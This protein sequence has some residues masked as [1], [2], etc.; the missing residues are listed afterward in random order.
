[1]ITFTKKTDPQP[2]PNDLE[3]NR[4]EQIRKAAKERQRQSATDGTRRRARH[5]AEDNKLI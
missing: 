5:T 1:M 3:E 4:F 2:I